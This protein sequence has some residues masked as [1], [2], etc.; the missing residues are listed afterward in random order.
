MNS[1]LIN[2]NKLDQYLNA[3]EFRKRQDTYI[4]TIAFVVVW[5]S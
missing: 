1:P 4:A 5:F 2:P 3:L